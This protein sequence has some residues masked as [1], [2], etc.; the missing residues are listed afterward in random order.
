MKRNKALSILLLSGLLLG[1]MPLHA[2][3][4]SP[5]VYADVSETD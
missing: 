5:G 3:A 4:G 1:L 2:R